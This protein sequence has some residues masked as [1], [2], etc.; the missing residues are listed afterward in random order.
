MTLISNF[1]TDV[2]CQDKQG[3]Y[4]VGEGQGSLVLISADHAYGDTSNSPSLTVVKPLNIYFNP[5]CG[6]ADC[7]HDK[8][9]RR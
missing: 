6:M 7:Y 5:V 9:A 2:K 8:H 4:S 3:C 1:E